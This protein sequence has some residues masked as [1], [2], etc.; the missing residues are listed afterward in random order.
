M[1]ELKY[2]AN[3]TVWTRYVNGAGETLFIVTSKPTRDK[4][5]I[6]ELVDG[7]FV[8]RGVAKEPP[9]LIEKC[10]VYERMRT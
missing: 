5:M 8:R 3:E 7:K 4:Y 9:E 6:Y 10:N 1:E 2:P